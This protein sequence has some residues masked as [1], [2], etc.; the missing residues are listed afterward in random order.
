MGPNISFSVDTRELENKLHELAKYAK[1]DPGI[2]MKDEVKQLSRAL[3]KLTPPSTFAQGRKAVAEDLGTSIY[4][5]PKS[6]QKRR[7]VG[8][9]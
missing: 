3:I 1:F 9:N 5:R 8:Q 7:K 4:D 6:H 2:V